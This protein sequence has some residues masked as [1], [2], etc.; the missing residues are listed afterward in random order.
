MSA[1][2]NADRYT[3]LIISRSVLLIIK[4]FRIKIVEK[5]KIF[6]FQQI[7]LFK[8]RTV[9][10]IIWKY[11]LVPDRPQ[12][13]LWRMRF[14]CW[15]SKAT[16]IYSEYVFFFFFHFNSGYANA[17]QCHVIRTLACLVTISCHLCRGVSSDFLSQLCR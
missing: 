16:N 7:L 15:I 5:I 3:F 2:V 14:A 11:M 9:Y 8:N 13:T 12:V 17:P 6:C 1:A 4:K 10:E